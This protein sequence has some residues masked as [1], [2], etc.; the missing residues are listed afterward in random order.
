M[1]YGMSGR[2]F[3]AP[4]LEA[5]P[6]FK[7]KA[8]TERSKKV[9]A[10]KYPDI[11]SYDTIDELL[12]DAE[13]ELIAVNTPGKTHYDFA[14]RTLLAGKHVLIEKPAAASVAE[15]KELFDLGRQQNKQVF[16]YQ[17]RRWDSDFQSLKQVI[18]SG[19]LG[20]LIELT[21]RFDR[22]NPVLSPKAFKEEGDSNAN[23]LVYDL[24]PHVLDQVISLFGKPL[25]YTKVTGRNRLGT[26][27][28]DYFFFQLSYPDQ[29]NVLVAGSLL[30]AQPM[31]AFV[32]HGTLGTYIKDRV[33]VQEAQLDKDKLP[34]DAAY[35]L[36]PAGSEGK[37]TTFA[38]DGSKR[39]ELTP[40]VKGNYMGLFEAV[41]QSIR[42]NQ[43]YPVT[44]E[45]IL[46]QIELLESHTS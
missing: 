36:E 42:N 43:P 18:K 23:G 44:E 26:Q 40:S 35:G 22:Y 17:N 16:V 6:G 39:A 31:P 10:G 27:V 32:A 9:A 37:L 2:I 38:G 30:T 11:I 19:K 45:N 33:D 14:K 7:L 46:T 24:G 13:I 21:V 28:D 5:H 15:V 29:L 20:K 25:R 3:Q 1:S 34:T 12:N 8:V 41:Y 4:F